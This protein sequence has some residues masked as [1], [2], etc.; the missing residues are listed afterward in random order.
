MYTCRVQGQ[1]MPD[2]MLLISLSH[3]LSTYTERIQQ[4]VSQLTNAHTL[5]GRPT[6]MMYTYSTVNVIVLRTTYF[7]KH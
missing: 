5:P 4:M 2:D 7:A 1:V 3:D 6:E